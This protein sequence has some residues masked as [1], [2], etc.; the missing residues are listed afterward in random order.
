[1][2]A[3]L[4]RAQVGC[5]R[6]WLALVVMCSVALAGCGIAKDPL[7]VAVGDAGSSAATAALALEQHAQ[8]RLTRST[9]E[10][11]IDDARREAATAAKQVTQLTVGDQQ[12]DIQ[13]DAMDVLARAA[14]HLQ[15][16]A[17][18]IGSDRA[19]ELI[20]ELRDDADAL[21]E[22]ESRAAASR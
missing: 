12:A 18:D 22:L 14:R 17:R 20:D 13:Q 1:M 11:M 7:S 4:P 9:A 19:E 3:V 15:Q 8:G 16:A 10:T 2:G 21:A 5:W 6:H